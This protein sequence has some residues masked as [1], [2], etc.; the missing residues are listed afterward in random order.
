[1]LLK[2]SAKTPNLLSEFLENIMNAACVMCMAGYI[3][4]EAERSDPERSGRFWF[5]E[6]IPGVNRF[7]LYPVGNDHWANVQEEG[8]CF[9]VLM[10]RY[11][12]DKNE[13]FANALASVIAARFQ[14]CA[15]II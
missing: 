3:P 2:I 8:D 13:L 14:H 7:C 12:Y 10:F 5:R 11:R 15:E 1:M 6:K 9:I 4:T